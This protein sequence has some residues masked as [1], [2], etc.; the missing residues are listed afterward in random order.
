ML[1]DNARFTDV[2]IIMRKFFAD[3]DRRPVRQD[4][5]YVRMQDKE[6]AQEYAAARP[7]VEY[8]TNPNEGLRDWLVI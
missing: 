8:H 5:L 6:D 2:L 4:I 7:N 1:Y 3:K